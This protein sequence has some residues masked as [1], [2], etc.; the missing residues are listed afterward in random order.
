MS[1]C[2]SDE[3]SV[4]EEGYEWEG[5]SDSDSD[6]NISEITGPIDTRGGGRKVRLVENRSCKGSL[7]EGGNDEASRTRKRRKSSLHD[8]LQPTKRTKTIKTRATKAL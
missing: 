8:L 7:F 3:G 5:E 1:I 2:G 6:S 4:S